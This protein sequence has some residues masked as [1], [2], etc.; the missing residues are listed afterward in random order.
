V[1]YSKDHSYFKHF[2][3][4]N[5]VHGQLFACFVIYLGHF[6]N[7]SPKSLSK[8]D[9]VTTN[10]STNCT[11]LHAIQALALSIVWTTARPHFRLFSSQVL[12]SSFSRSSF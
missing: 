12:K 8:A 10:T 4:Y 1:L 9:F 7:N 3:T 11:F 5:A 6:D 2:A